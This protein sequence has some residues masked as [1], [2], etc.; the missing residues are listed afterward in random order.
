MHKWHSVIHGNQHS[1]VATWEGLAYP[2]SLQAMPMLVRVVVVVAEDVLYFPT[3]ERCIFCLGFKPQVMTTKAFFY[4]LLMTSA[5][6]K[7]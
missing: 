7:H 2:V 6:G 3:H 1:I 5:G 4:T